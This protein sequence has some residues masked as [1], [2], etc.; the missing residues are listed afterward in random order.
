MKTILITGSTDGIGLSAAQMLAAEGHRILLHGRNA[1]KLEKIKTS[2]ESTYTD[3]AFESYV[4]DLSDLNQVRVMANEIAER[5]S[6]LDVLINNAG[7][8]GVAEPRTPIGL[9]V[10]FVVN[11][12]APYLLTKLLLPLMDK[13]ARIINL[14]SA[15][16]APV[17]P[18]AFT[19]ERQLNHSEAYAQSKLAITMWSAQMGKTLKEKGIVVVAV[20]PKSFLGSKMVK[21]AYG[22]DGYDINIGGEVLR[23]AALDQ[24][25]SHAF[26]KYYDNDKGRFSD[27][28]PHAMDEVKCKAVR[29]MI[30]AIL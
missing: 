21:Q 3:A 23:K 11:T 15:A 5:H 4:A 16:Q 6:S 27:P 14:S 25:F 30:E 20:N 19:G 1:A 13:G 22:M 10:R 2:L 12:I 9:D 17:D 28:H 18:L 29:D 24:D 7:V 26:G 8:F